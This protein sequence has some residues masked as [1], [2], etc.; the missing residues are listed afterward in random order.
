MTKKAQEVTKEMVGKALTSKETPAEPLIYCGPSFPGGE[1]QQF[2]IYK[3]GIPK[4]V[5]EIKKECPAITHLF[6]PVSQLAATR[7]N[8]GK[9]GSRDHQ[10]FSAVTNYLNERSVNK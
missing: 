3:N 7:V 8:F 6:K 4:N 1:L 5:E 10:L 9:V 2:S